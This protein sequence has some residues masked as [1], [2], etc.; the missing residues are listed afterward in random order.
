MHMLTVMLLFY[1]C[2]E[3]LKKYRYVNTLVRFYIKVYDYFE[4]CHYEDFRN[5]KEICIG[6]CILHDIKKVRKNDTGQA[7]VERIR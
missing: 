7:F 2:V 1:N 5:E 6:S 4:V 3:I